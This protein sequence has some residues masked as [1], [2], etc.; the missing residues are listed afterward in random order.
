MDT[1]QEPSEFS[2]PAEAA[3]SSPPSSTTFTSPSLHST[4]ELESPTS[5][6]ST[7][8]SADGSPD[9]DSK[10]QSPI[11]RLMERTGYSIIQQNGQRRYGPPPDWDGP[12]PPR[13]CE[14]FVGKIPRDCFEDELVPVFER[15]GDVYE[16]RLMMEYSGQ[17]R[18]YAF[19]V[20]RS[21]CEAKEAAKIL[22]NYEIRK[23]RTLGICMSV[24]NCRLFV[25]GIPKKVLRREGGE[26]YKLC[27]LS[28]LGE[29]MQQLPAWYWWC[30]V[31]GEEQLMILQSSLALHCLGCP[32]QLQVYSAAFNG[33]VAPH[34]WA[35]G[36]IAGG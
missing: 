36:N 15:A 25:G 27:M 10:T 16:M 8:L 21:P 19:V 9:K 33:G 17:N 26:C 1:G 18:G 23:G 20:Y 30:R 35:H 7:E 4:S 2:P 14:V 34:Y 29:C 22:N 32:Y 11:A 31:G 5:T 28:R 6:T 3:P 12:P 13:G 24:D